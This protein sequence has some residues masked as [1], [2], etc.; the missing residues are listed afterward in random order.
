MNATQP[1]NPWRHPWKHLRWKWSQ[2][3]D[4]E[5]QGYKFWG[6]V[7]VAITA[8]ELGGVF[9]KSM[10]RWG[11]PWHTISS[12]IGH[13]EDMHPW[14]GVIVVA[15]IGL[16]VFY[17]YIYAIQSGAA[18]SPATTTPIKVSVPRSRFTFRYG[19]PTVLVL[20]GL[21]SWIGYETLHGDYELSYVIYS[22]SLVFGI[23]LPLA[24]TR[25]AHKDVNFPSLF[26]TL[27]YLRV[28][29]LFLAAFLFAWIGVAIVHLALYPWPNLA[30]EPAKY[31]GRTATSAQAAASHVVDDRWAFSVARR[32]VDNG[33]EVWR[34]YFVDGKGP[35]CVVTVPKDDPP[36]T[37]GAC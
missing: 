30:R 8:T 16:S 36:T 15:T 33:R 14:F 9:S 34:V 32:D 25:W 4:D 31:A 26:A 3:S 1:P 13:L 29:F 11:A 24:L 22:A 10:K 23:L 21:T 2:A 17:A 35:A 37:S 7:A 12:T 20:T 6:P 28:R 19:W 5:K 27:R 18:P